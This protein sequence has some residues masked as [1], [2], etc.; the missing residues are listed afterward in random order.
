MRGGLI[1][2]SW[3]VGCTVKKKK[4][5]WALDSPLDGLWW[6]GQRMR[7]QECCPLGPDPWGIWDIGSPGE[8]VGF[9]RHGQLCLPPAFSQNLALTFHY[10][11]QYMGSGPSIISTFTSSFLSP[12]ALTTDPSPSLC[13]H[14]STSHPAPIMGFYT[15]HSRRLSWCLWWTVLWDP[16]SPESLPVLLPTSHSPLWLHSPP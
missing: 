6:W 2:G 8:T 5:S 3:W 13:L 4:G 1:Q 14:G 16:Y 15:N 10:G 11:P 12:Q 9:G 7:K